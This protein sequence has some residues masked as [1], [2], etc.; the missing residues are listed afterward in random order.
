MITGALE[1][2]NEWDQGPKENR[3]TTGS[4]GSS[5]VYD[6]IEVDDDGDADDEAFYQKNQGFASSWDADMRE[7][8]RLMNE[9]DEKEKRAVNVSRTL[10][11]LALCTVAFIVGHLVYYFV[12]QT[13]ANDFS[14]MVSRKRLRRGKDCFCFVCVCVLPCSRVQG[15]C[16][17]K[18]SSPSNISCVLFISL[19]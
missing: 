12:K 19:S 16:D 13:E 15:Q 17:H 4:V 2:M 10:V 1:F 5:S 3:N 14:D 6:E 18:G 8:E 7:R 9:Q 11:L